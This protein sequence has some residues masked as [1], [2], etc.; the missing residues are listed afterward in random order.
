VTEEVNASQMKTEESSTAVEN[1]GAEPVFFHS[2]EVP[3]SV[4]YLRTVFN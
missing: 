1:T 3:V 2:F 4:D